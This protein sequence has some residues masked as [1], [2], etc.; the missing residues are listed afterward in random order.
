MQSTFEHVNV[1]ANYTFEVNRALHRLD[2][3]APNRPEYG[4]WPAEGTET[5]LERVATM[6]TPGVGDSQ[7]SRADRFEA[8]VRPHYDMLHRTAFYWTRSSEDA[9]DLV[10]ELCVRAFPKLRELETLDRP[11]G[12][13]IRVMYRLFVD[14]TRRPT[15]RPHPGDR[16]GAG[17]V[18]ATTPARRES[19]AHSDERGQVLFRA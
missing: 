13:L 8:L 1:G 6:A 2:I 7:R 12:W 16:P 19:T 17:H 14:L 15:P 4:S 3:I 11:L 5:A 9:E 18:A 10:Q